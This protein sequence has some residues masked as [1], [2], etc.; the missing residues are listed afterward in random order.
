MDRLARVVAVEHLG[1][2]QLRITF[3]DDLVRELDFGGVLQGGV[4]TELE[5][6]STFAAVT[7]DEIAGTVCWPNG[8]DLDP[9]VLHGDS[10]PAT[11]SS[12][13]LLRQYS[14]RPTG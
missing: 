11:G 13:R 4:F 14:L 7:V 9:D 6:E 5:D 2:F 3:S 8:V 12:P 10:V 1:A